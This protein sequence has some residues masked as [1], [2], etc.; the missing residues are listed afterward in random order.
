LEA[1]RGSSTVEQGTA[2]GVQRRRVCS[3]GRGGRELVREL[4]ESEV[5]LKVGSVWAERVWNGG[6]T[7]SFE[8]AGVRVDNS[9]VL[10]LWGRGLAKERTD[11]KAGVLMVPMRTKERAAGLY[12]VLSTATTR[13]RTA[14]RSGARGTGWRVPTRGQGQWR[15]PA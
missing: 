4:R 3:G 2:R 7:M 9:G 8:L 12:L 15:G 5:K 14:G 13:W 10:W 6:S 1:G 11:W